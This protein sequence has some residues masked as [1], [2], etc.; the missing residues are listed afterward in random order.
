MTGEEVVEVVGDLETA[1]IAVSL[2][3]GL[4]V[5][6][7]LEE[8]TRPHDDLDLVVELSDAVGVVEVLRKRCYALGGG[9]APKSFELVD[10]K[11]RQVDVH[12][13]VFSE[14]GDGTYRMANDEDWMYPA[15]GFAGVGMVLGRRVRCLTPEVQVLCHSCY[16]P[17]LTSFDDVW[18][19]SE[20]FGI[21]VPSEY[22]RPREAYAPRE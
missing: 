16:E 20:R 8:Q 21:P 3:G 19:L 11:G 1:A 10:D 18:A 12:P 22:R 5:D 17:H 4:A 13:V 6:A 15:S 2:D 7:A 9:G 14:S